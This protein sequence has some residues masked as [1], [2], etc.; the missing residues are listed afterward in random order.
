MGQGDRH[1]APP[2][3][4]AAMAQFGI[5]CTQHIPWARHGCVARPAYSHAVVFHRTLAFMLSECC[6]PSSFQGNRSASQLFVAMTKS[7]VLGSTRNPS[8]RR[9]LAHRKSDTVSK[10]GCSA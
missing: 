7:T 5:S 4:G 6:D 2:I 8:W 9:N 10:V 3:S 1:L